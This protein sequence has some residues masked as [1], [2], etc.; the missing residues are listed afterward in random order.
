MI[1]RM[2][3][4]SQIARAEFVSLGG[5]RRAFYACPAGPGPFP[6]VLV[7]QEAFG[8]NEYVQSEARRLAER[9]YVAIAP[10]LFHG[11][12]FPYDFSKV[13]P[14]LQSLTD[15]EMLADVDAAIAFL[16]GRREVK[17]ARFGVVGFCM[18]GRLAALVALARPDRI[19][20]AASFYGGGIA[21]EQVRFFTPIVDRFATLDG[22]L[23]LIY[24]ADDESIAPKEHA[25]IADTLSSLK[26]RYTISVYPGAPH[27][28]A[29]VDRPSYRRDQAEAA[30]AE[31]LALFA[32][33]L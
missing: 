18:G 13:M 5:D 15:Q 8:V 3:Q 29:S 33:T 27:A 11:E 28:F 30:W 16:D 14:K 7:L 12:T 9:G 10:D 22:E 1:H 32:R 2:Q 17:K 20:A 25:R 6:A 26:K 31:T 23:L 24:G 21:P 19:A 4:T